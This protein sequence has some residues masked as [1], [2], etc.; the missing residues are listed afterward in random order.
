M[1]NEFDDLSLSDVKVDGKQL[2]PAK[3]AA[4]AETPTDKVETKA[5][6]AKADPVITKVEPVET[7]AEPAKVDPVETKAEPA[8]VAPSPAPEYKFKDDFIK[9]VVEYYEK[10]GGFTDYI[11]AKS[12]DYSKLTDEEIMKRDLK[13][14]YASL[15]D[16]AFDA[17]YKEQ[18]TDKFKLDADAHGAEA[19]EVGREFLKLEADAKRKE[20]IEKQNAFKAPER[21]E[22][23]DELEA[24]AAVEKQVADFRNATAN[25]AETK[26]LLE[27]KTL[28]IKIGEATVNFEVSDPQSVIDS[29]LDSTKFFNQFR[30]PDGSIDYAKWYKVAAYSQNLELYEKTLFDKGKAEGRDEITKEIKNPTD[31]KGGDPATEGSGDFTTGL[32][33]AFAKRGKHS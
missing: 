4:P 1:L 17:L 12:I 13:S 21:V 14:K 32:L 22:D 31:P 19:T 7:K 29:T 26:S 15:S 2:E 23:A 25:H 6:P 10:T 5:E 11:D 24:R 16:K 18:V 3:P 28:P 20:L 33:E 30:N 27:G 8:E 9:G